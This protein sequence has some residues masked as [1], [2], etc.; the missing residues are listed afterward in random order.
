MFEYYYFSYVIKNIFVYHDFIIFTSLF[1]SILF[2]WVYLFVKLFTSY[3]SSRFHG[4]ELSRI[5]INQ[6]KNSKIFYK[7]NS[8]SFPFVSIILPARNEEENIKKCLNS[9]LSQ[10]Y[11]NFEIIAVDDNSTDNT[12]S[13]MLEVQKEYNKKQ[14][15]KR[16]SK[17]RQQKSNYPVLK[18]I[19]LKDKPDDWAGKTW[20][21]EQG[22]LRSTGSILLFTDA[23]TIYKKNVISYT[24]SYMISKKLDVITGDPFIELKDFWSKIS[25]PLWRLMSF[26]LGKD[27]KDI[28]NPKSKVALLM[29]CFF[30]IKRNVF[31]SIGT[32]ESVKNAIQED[33]AL[34]VRIKELGFKLRMIPM[35]NLIRA[36]WSRDLST[37]WNGIGRTLTPM[38]FKEKE[39]I[40]INFMSIILLITLPHM[41]LIYT[42][43]INFTYSTS[44]DTSNN[45][46]IFENYYNILLIFNLTVCLMSLIGI[47]IKTVK[48]YKINPLYTLLSP[49]G[50][51][52]L[53]IAYISIII[54]F[55]L[56]SKSIEWK[57]RT[58]EYK[59]ND[60]Q[61]M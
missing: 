5:A 51:I 35:D 52:F 15:K 1:A 49:V 18:V 10:D 9:L 59:R 13:I 19:S 39:K 48:T 58:F 34:G 24:I 6:Y 17:L 27:V 56:S 22:Y 47:Y 57:G 11:G 26:T 21:S 45:I 33:Q 32:F 44:P 31:E 36:L 43:Y 54:S 53:I 29:G 23:D 8:L 3:C 7:K 30:M 16:L 12:L 14:K 50:S 4:N 37:L 28:N 20:A 55:M 38:I 41:L 61:I 42:I 25:M 40:F 46:Y 2:G 60:N